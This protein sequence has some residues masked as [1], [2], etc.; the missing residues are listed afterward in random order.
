[1]GSSANA[2]RREANRRRFNGT[3]E[4]AFPEESESYEAD[5]ID[6]SIGGMSL[7]TAFLPDV[8]SELDC[9]FVIDGHEP[10]TVETRAEVMWAKEHG[11]DA[12][13]FGLR[14]KDMSPGDRAAVE[15]L[16][17]VN[18]SKA[19]SKTKAQ[20]KAHSSQHNHTDAKVE[21]HAP[22][23]HDDSVRL[24]LPTMPK[25]LKATLRTEAQDA[26]VIAMDLSFIELGGHLEVDRPNGS[27]SKGTIEGVDLDIDPQSNTARLVLTVALES[28]TTPAV[29]APM[30]MDVP[31]AM[32]PGKA[33]SVQA[34]SAPSKMQAAAKA[35]LSAHPSPNNTES[36]TSMDSMGDDQ[37][38]GHDDHHQ[39]HEDQ[40]AQQS[41]R[42][43][44][45]S[46]LA[47]KSQNA[48]PAWLLSTISKVRGAG[49]TVWQNA[50]PALRKTAGMIAALVLLISQRVR[51]KITG[52]PIAAPVVEA[53]KSTTAAPSRSAGKISLRKQNPE[54]EEPVDAVTSAESSTAPSARRKFALAGLG[55]FGVSA[56]AFAL[57]TGRTEPRPQTPRPQVAV[58]DS[59]STASAANTATPAAGAAAQPAITPA[60]GESEL[61]DPSEQ[62]AAPGTAPTQGTARM[63]S[64][65]VAA[66]RSRNANLEPGDVTTGPTRRAAVAAP[67]NAR[68]LQAARA[69]AQAPVAGGQSIGNASLR[70]GTVLR[71][72][73][74]G[75]LTGITGGAAGR[76]TITIQVQGRHIV[77]RAAG[78]ARM[79]SRIAGAGA[80]NRGAN[81]EFTLRF[82]GTAPSF[83]ARTRGDTLE[84]I[85]A[86]PAAGSHVSAAANAHARIASI[87]AP[88]RR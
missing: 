13:S 7:K 34:S 50:G 73:C 3:V 40:D 53:H 21:A 10:T 80:Y 61:G 63:P 17:E 38:H 85:L 28:A 37:D 83:A 84:V 22:A 31:F 11:G 66:A 78:L 60:N 42:G 51:S 48:A 70:T 15:M 49:K 46:S 33:Q 62:G 69:P 44:N 12:G 23:V 43:A 55:M 45:S 81:S 25:P 52:K 6:L 64:D 9:R 16:C 67:A 32:K 30:V 86:A 4:L 77:D 36:L 72:R 56:I 19:K 58:S 74:D 75:R 68:T 88:H 47:S 29:N 1:M 65:L 27:K 71:L 87:P 54:K 26:M 24:R 18:N 20:S 5:G 57:V 59:N 14:F 41:A 79:D 76:N 2:E 8:G 82:N 39:D 35:K